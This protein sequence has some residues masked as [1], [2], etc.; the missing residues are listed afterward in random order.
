[1]SQFTYLPLYNSDLPLT[2]CYGDLLLTSHP[3][4]E[5]LLTSHFHGDLQFNKQILTTYYPVSHLKHEDV[6]RKSADNECK[7]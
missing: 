2:I 1:M 6:W 7:S 4:S 3:Y 5:L